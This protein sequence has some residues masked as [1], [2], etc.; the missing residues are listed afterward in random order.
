MPLPIIIFTVLSLIGGAAYG[1]YQFYL[2][3]LREKKTNFLKN[4]RFPSGLL[5]KFSKI[6]PQYNEQQ[7]CYIFETL[8][9]FFL[10][11][12]RVDSAPVAMPSK[13]VD[14]AWHEFI[15][16]TRE[17]QLFCEK[18][19]GR[20]QHHT[21]SEGMAKPRRA[22]ETLQ[23]TWAY[24]CRLHSINPILPT[25]LPPLF[26]IDTDLDVEGGY[27][28]SLTENDEAT[29]DQEH[30]KNR[31]SAIN[32]RCMRLPMVN[33]GS[34]SDK[35]SS[36]NSKRDTISRDNTCTSHTS[37]EDGIDLGDTSDSGCSSCGGG[38]GGD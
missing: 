35:N 18:G 26:S 1:Y 36:G 14:Q 13:V 30:Q 20:F 24:S 33:D 7:L 16:F 11:C 31:F 22:Q 38:C 5:Q 3:Y 32:I 19:F 27:F 29:S 25:R 8:K 9:H 10:I 34:Y 2:P 37:L 15:L 6:Y 28:Y 4:Y 21:P 12:D 23:R 17:Y